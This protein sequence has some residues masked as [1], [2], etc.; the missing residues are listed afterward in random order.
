MSQ[1]RLQAFAL[2]VEQLHARF[3]LLQ[4][5]FPLL[6]FGLGHC[7][8]RG[9]KR[10]L[11]CLGLCGSGRLVAR[12]FG[13]LALAF[14]LIEQVALVV[15][16]IAVKGLDAAACDHPELVADRA[17]QRPVVADQHHR[18][19]KLVQRHGQRL[20]RG[21]IQVVGGL[22]HQQEVGPLPD[23]H[24]QDQPRLL[25]PAHAAHGLLDHVAAEIEGA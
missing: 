12:A 4:L 14:G 22:V 5:L 6:V 7:F 17:Q 25:A 15:V 16:Q 20:A 24:A 11:F 18:A 2:G 10:C 3:G 23:D 1:L 8:R 19:F 13:F 21:Q 9:R